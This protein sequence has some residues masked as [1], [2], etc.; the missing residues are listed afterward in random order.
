VPCGETTLRTAGAPDQ[1]LDAV[2]KVCR[3][4]GHRTYREWV[5]FFPAVPVRDVV[6]SEKQG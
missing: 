4:V 1:G 2:S 5:V 3:P 6:V